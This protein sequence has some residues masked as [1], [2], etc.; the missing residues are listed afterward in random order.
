MK[1]SSLKNC[2]QLLQQ[3]E[4]EQRKR[5]MNGIPALYPHRAKYIITNFRGT[6]A[7]KYKSC[8]YLPEKFIGFPDHIF[9]LCALSLCCDI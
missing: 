5:L 1:K 3:E 9:W 4:R 6:E 7:I 8:Q 2:Y